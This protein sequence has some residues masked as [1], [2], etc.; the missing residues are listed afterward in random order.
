MSYGIW[1]SRCCKLSYFILLYGWVIFHCVHLLYSFICWWTFRW[2]PCLRDCEQCC[3]EPRGV[4]I[5]LKYS[6]IQIYAQ[7]WDCRVVGSY[8]NSIYRSL[9]NLHTVFHSGYTIHS[10]GRFPFPHTLSSTKSCSLNGIIFKNAIIL[11]ILFLIW[12]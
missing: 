8:D 1:L 5:F 11:T 6:F 3:Y 2:F 9:K 10:L 12:R 4:C 7:E